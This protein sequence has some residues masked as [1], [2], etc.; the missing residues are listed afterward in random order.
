MNNK[1]ESLNNIDV[2]IMDCEMPIMNGYEAS[3][4]IKDKIDKNSYIDSVIIG[5][6]GLSGEEEEEK[7]RLNGMDGYIFKPATK[8]YF[9]EYMCDLLSNLREF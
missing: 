7:C 3:K 6:T 8:N 1:K 9:C 2:I 4:K 5:Y